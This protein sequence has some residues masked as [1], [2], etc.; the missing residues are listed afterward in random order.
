MTTEHDVLVEAERAL[1]ENLQWLRDKLDLEI[2]Q[3]DT[4]PLRRLAQLDAA[5]QKLARCVPHI[6]ATLTVTKEIEGAKP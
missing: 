3:G 4:E 5:W 1:G 6:Q 2:R